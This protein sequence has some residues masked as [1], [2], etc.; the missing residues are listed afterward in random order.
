MPDEHRELIEALEALRPAAVIAASDRHASMPTFEDPE[1]S[2]RSLTVPLDVAESL[3]SGEQIRIV[4]RGATLPGHGVTISARAGGA[5]RR[6][7]V[8]AHVDAKV[9]T[10]GAFDNAASVAAVL[11]LAETV[12]DDLGPVEFVFFNGED[13]YDACGEVAWLAATDL[14]EVVGNVNL[15]GAGVA[16][17]RT[18]ITCLM[19]PPR[20]EDQ[21]RDAIGRSGWT[22]M[23]PWFESDHAIFAMRGI[24]AVAITSE[25]VHDLLLSVAHTP[26]DTLDLVDMDTLAEI[27]DVLRDLLP[28]LRRTLLS[29]TAA[30]V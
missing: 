24:P 25:D 16:G 2:F 8:S 1:L 9:T 10:P 14:T 26:A 4:F 6:L 12:T 27:V 7:V 29:A 21:V 22:F 5:S 15:D 28:D 17:R 23:P 13:H 11:V 30:E 19:C 3:R 18:G 20:A